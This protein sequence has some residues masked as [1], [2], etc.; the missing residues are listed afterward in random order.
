MPRAAGFLFP[1][2]K[3]QTAKAESRGST[4]NALPAKPA[5]RH[6]MNIVCKRYF[7][8]QRFRLY[9]GVGKIKGLDATFSGT[10]GISIRYA[11]IA[12]AFVVHRSFC[13]CVFC[14]VPQ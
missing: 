6:T 1:S 10:A 13:R 14:A 12:A 11:K 7:A 3:H 9:R 2:R 8:S 4:S 5:H